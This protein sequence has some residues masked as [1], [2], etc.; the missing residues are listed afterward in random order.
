MPFRVDEQ[1]SYVAWFHLM[2]EI[3]EPGPVGGEAR[4][5]RGIE[6]DGC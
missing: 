2:N 1:E 5:C 4:A 3:N 6:H